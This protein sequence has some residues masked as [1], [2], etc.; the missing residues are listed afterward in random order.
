MLSQ[1]FEV[2]PLVRQCEE[3]LEQFK[4][5]KKHFDSVKNVELSYPPCRP[6]CMAFSSGLPLNLQKLREFLLSGEY[7][8]VNIYVEGLGQAVKS[9][10]VILSL[11]SVPFAK[12]S[13]FLCLPS[14]FILIIFC[15]LT[16][17]EYLISIFWYGSVY[18]FASVRPYIMLL[19]LSFS[20]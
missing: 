3:I 5:N 15:Q 4:L 10:K 13:T 9:H 18:R 2:T 19:K 14:Y 7:S 17:I 11:W 8:D 1:Q 12:V 20:I 6:Q 16:L